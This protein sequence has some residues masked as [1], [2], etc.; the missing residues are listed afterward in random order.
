MKA[1]ILDGSEKH[2]SFSKHINEAVLDVLHKKKTAVSNYTLNQYEINGCVGCLNCF[3]KNPGTCVFDDLVKELPRVFIDC[4]LVI[5]I[6]PVTF[7]GY[8]S[9]LAKAYDRL[10]IQL[11]SHLFEVSHGKMRRQKRYQ[12][13]HPSLIVIG[14]E[15]KANVENREVFEALVKQNDFEHI[16]SPMHQTL[17]FVEDSPFDTIKTEIYGAIVECGGV[18]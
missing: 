16:H 15:E 13:N 10:I 3:F 18:Q 5:L 12:Q 6:T 4:D 1:M 14:V 7:G 11:E 17:F 9:I 2:D 8:S